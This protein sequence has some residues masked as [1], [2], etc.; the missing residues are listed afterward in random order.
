LLIATAGFFLNASYR[1]GLLNR[2]TN[3]SE[4]YFSLY[5]SLIFLKV[6][7][8]FPFYL[9]LFKG[10]ISFSLLPLELASALSFCAVV[11]FE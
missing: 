5:F 3:F 11:L 4:P 6:G 1:L 2:F 10:G 9:L 8:L 7:K